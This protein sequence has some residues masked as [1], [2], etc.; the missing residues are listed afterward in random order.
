M[1]WGCRTSAGPLDEEGQP[2]TI[3]V[4]LRVLTGA[5]LLELRAISPEGFD[6]FVRCAADLDDADA[7]A[8]ALSAALGV[9]LACSRTCN[10]SPSSGL[11][12]HLARATRRKPRTDRRPSWR[13]SPTGA[14][15][16]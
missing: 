9:A 7:S 13:S 5:G 12:V 2:T 10:S 15:P 1:C 3:P 6:L 16:R 11:R 14:C 4:D 8:I